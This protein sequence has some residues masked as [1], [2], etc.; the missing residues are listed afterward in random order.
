[1]RDAYLSSQL[2]NKKIYY[3]IFV[4]ILYYRYYI[5]SFYFHFPLITFYHYRLHLFSFTITISNIIC[6]FRERP[7]CVATFTIFSSYFVTQLFDV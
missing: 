3:I 2:K 6:Y 1:M 7:Q 4:D 5:L